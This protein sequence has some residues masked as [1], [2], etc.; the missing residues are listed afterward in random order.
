MSVSASAAESDLARLVDVDAVGRWLVEQGVAEGPVQLAGALGGGTQNVLALLRVDGRDLVLRRGPQHLRP[1][2]NDMLRREMR[3]LEALRGTDVPHPRLVASCS[4]ED[5]LGGAVFY[6][7]EAVDGFN[8]AVALEGAAAG[9]ADVR[10]ALAFSTAKAAA[11]LAAVDHEAVGLGDLG[12][13]DGFLER[14]V[15]RWRAELDS[16]RSLDGYAGDGLPGV[17]A[18][19]EW[20]DVHQPTQWRP[21]ILHGDYHLSNVMCSRTTGEVVAVVDWEM[22]T[23]GDPLLDLGWLLA[24]WPREQAPD[25][26]VEVLPDGV[27]QLAGAVT[28]DELVAEYARHSV[29]DVSAVDW[30]EVLAC[31]KLAIVLE[32]TH[33]RACAGLAPRDVGDRLH[34]G[35]LELLRR[36]RE[37]TVT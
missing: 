35:S 33:A 19:G 23:I 34:Q 36:A 37:I 22:T 6:V 5:V 27:R 21:G 18:V 30:Y 24:T 20:L 28:R 26:G 9:S 29:R 4:D 14:Q 15:G 11:S 12:K 25:E 13:P 7:M 32:G 31:Y 10:R 17:D 1:R 16:Y 3:V 2:T 8:P